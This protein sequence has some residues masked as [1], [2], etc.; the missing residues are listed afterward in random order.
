[1]IIWQALKIIGETNQILSRCNHDVITLKK[2]VF[3]GK[4]LLIR[5]FSLILQFEQKNN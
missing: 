3:V 2:V 5:V 1:M 4:W